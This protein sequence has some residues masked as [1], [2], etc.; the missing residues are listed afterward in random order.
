MLRD[1]AGAEPR[2]ELRR[3]TAKLGGCRPDAGRGPYRSSGVARRLGK[4]TSA[5]SA[6]RQ[7]LI[8]KGL[9]YATE[10]YDH[11]DVTVPRFDDFMPRAALTFK[12]LRG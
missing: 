2:E 6:I 5:L 10:D 7:R 8:D 3:V 1:A 9:I 12:A 4:G 11:I